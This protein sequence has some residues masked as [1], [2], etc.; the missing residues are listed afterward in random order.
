EDILATGC[1][2]NPKAFT[3]AYFHHPADLAAELCEVGFAEPTV[4]GVEGPAWGLLKAAEDHSG[5]ALSDS[6]MFEAARVVALMAEPYPE[7]LAASSHLLAIATE[8][9]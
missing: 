8:R 2:R 9:A 5:D 4:Y 6:R 3:T 1:L 7:L